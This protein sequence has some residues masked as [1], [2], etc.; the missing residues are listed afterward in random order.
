[1]AGAGRVELTA[2]EQTVLSAVG[3]RLT[4]TEIA[5]HYVISVRTVES[6]IA[7]LR[8]KLAVDTR[9]G[10]IDAARQSRESRAVW[11]VPLPQNSFV[12]RADELAVLRSRLDEQR[13]V[14]VVGPAGCGK[15]RLALELAASDC[16]I[17]VVVELQDATETRVPEAIAK[18]VGLDTSEDQDLLAACAI[19]L[20]TRDHLL[21]LD[22]C[23]RVTP[24][25]E[26]ALARVL[27]RAPTVT[28]L[29]TSRTPVGGAGES[30][31]ALSPLRSEGVDSPA[32]LLFLDRARAASAGAGSSPADVA[33]AGQ[34]CRRLDGLP[35]AIEL[36]AAR[37]RHLPLGELAA[38][39]QLDLG[40]LDRSASPG[41][42]HT[43]EAAFDWTW[44]LLDVDERTALKRLAALPRTFD[45]DLAEAVCGPGGGALLLRLLDRSLVSPTVHV[46]EPRRFRLL[47]SLKAFV[48]ARTDQAVIDDVGRS[49]AQFYGHLG[50]MVRGLARTD[51]SD[52]MAETARRLCP[53]FNAA[54]EWAL[55]HDRRLVLPLVLSLAIGG[56]Q[57]GHTG[58][59]LATIE[60]A[61]THPEVREQASAQEICELGLALCYGDLDVVAGL[62]RLALTKIVDERSEL[63]AHHLAGYADAYRHEGSRALEHLDRAAVLA[64]QQQDDWQ[65]G[66][67]QQG[68]GIALRGAAVTDPVGAMAAFTSAMES[69]A[70]AGDAMHVNNVRYMLAA[71]AA[72]SRLRLEEADGWV[73]QCVRYTVESANT[74]ELAHALLT[75]ARLRP[76][77]PSA[78]ADLEQSAETFR[79]VGDLRCLTRARFEQASSATGLARVA[80]LDQA[81]VLAR[82]AH[83]RGHETTALQRLVVA[84]WEVGDHHRAFVTLGTLGNLVAPAEALAA[85]PPEMAAAVSAWESAIQEGRAHR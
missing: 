56:E 12:G 73:D 13:W 47:E 80:V 46:W 36:A 20:S 68:R 52:L 41:G 59:S 58:D 25:V 78:A 21:V 3:R 63:A 7:S 43:L 30:L 18:A 67:V 4:N 33:L 45:L 81:L 37:V 55:A 34:V 62:G 9:A 83:D 35:L 53:E 32:V 19:A 24:A 14:T 79:W 16:R 50:D 5:D 72:D 61:A 27:Q 29:A 23:D 65:L 26:V 60:R 48:H 8:R 28:V 6:H 74:H 39:L 69:F 57:Y 70:R 77:V 51:D 54:V 2:R 85:C 1:M 31:F 38:R 75:R 76:D 71:T 11:T 22:N 40:W 49:H 17:P 42:H 10:L 15:T 44:D 64:E 66:S 84:H 82:T